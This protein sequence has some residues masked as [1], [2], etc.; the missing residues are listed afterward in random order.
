MGQE[1]EEQ[2]E[3]FPTL[4]FLPSFFLP[5]LSMIGTQ[6]P[7]RPCYPFPNPFRFLPLKSSYGIW[8]VASSP[9][10]SGVERRLQMQL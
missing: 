10:G 5:S 2:G 1:F 6:Y 4:P 3:T 9:G 8:S 7:S